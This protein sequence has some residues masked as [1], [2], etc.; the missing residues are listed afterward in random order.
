MSTY[1]IT[2]PIYY[3]NDRPHIGHCYTTLLADVA[4]RFQRLRHGSP[5]DVFFLTG[6]DEH[7]EKVVQ[8][9]S[10]NGMSPIQWADRNADEFRKA[11]GA[12]DFTNDDFVRTTEDRHKTKAS[13]YI[14]Q[15]VD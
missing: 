3:V 13:A 9:A 4:A 1:Y 2:T 11:F 6:T 8:S 5:D 7:A 10:D 14:Q 15:L 12:M